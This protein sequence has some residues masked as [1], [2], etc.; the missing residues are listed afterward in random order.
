MP[1]QQAP[2]SLEYILL[3]FLEQNPI[4]GY[5]LFKRI[6]NFETISLVWN[7]KQSQL[8]ALLDRL[9]VDGLI[10]STLI[11]G[12][13]R[14]NR[15]QY[16]ITS[17]GRQTFYA[18]RSSPVQHGRDIRIEFLAKIFFA[19]MAGPEFVLDLI[20]AQKE[21]CF[22]WLT[23]FQNDLVKTMDDQ[24]YQRIVFEYRIRQVQATLDWLETTRKEL[25]Y[26]PKIVEKPKQDPVYKKE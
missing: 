18:W 22:E 5:D 1:R 23:Q 3:G 11:P 26:Q 17:I 10:T 13:S 20:E 9:E 16:C 6:S 4:H 21:Q 7:I 24:S 12:E 19:L 15:K 25:A 8:Y 2:L 14:P